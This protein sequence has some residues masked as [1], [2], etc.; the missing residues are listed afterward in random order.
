MGRVGGRVGG[1]WGEGGGRVGGGWRVGGR[2]AGGL[3]TIVY[4]S[5]LKRGWAVD[6]SLCESVEK[7]V[8]C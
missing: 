6:H 5:Q 4:V 3:L 8:G 7:G 2:V 1:G